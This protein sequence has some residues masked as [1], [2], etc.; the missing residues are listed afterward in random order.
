MKKPKKH[1]L[2]IFKVLEAI[3]R[4]DFTF[5]ERQTDVARKAFVPTTALRW[6]SIAPDGPEAEAM[7]WLVNE[8]ANADYYAITDHPELQFK[9]L[10]AAGL[11]RKLRHQWINL[12]KKQGVA[13]FSILCDFLLEWHPEANDDEINILLMQFTRDIFIDFI[14]SC[15]KDKK[16]TKELIDAWD[17]YHGVK[18][19]SQ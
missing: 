11:G 2:D 15:A 17:K 3:D 18:T 12:P 9:L 13:G 6:A 19:K 4:R 8:Y 10:A 5:L 7:L 14:T 16:Q 1:D